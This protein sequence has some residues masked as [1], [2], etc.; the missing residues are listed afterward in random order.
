MEQVGGTTMTVESS[1]T[2]DSRSPAMSTTTVVTTSTSRVRTT[3]SRGTPTTVR[4]STS[5]TR[6]GQSSTTVGFLEPSGEDPLRR[7]DVPPQGVPGQLNF[8]SPTDGGCEERGPVPSVVPVSETREIGDG[9][10]VCISGFEASSPVAVEVSVPGGEIRRRSLSNVP[11]GN[12]WDFKLG[13]TDPVGAYGI[14][15]VQGR[16][17]VTGGFT[18]V[19]PDRPIIEAVPPSSGSP[20]TVF[21]FSIVSPGPTQRVTIDLYR[22]KT[23]ATTLGTIVTDAR[24]RAT[25]ELRT[26]R[27]S[28]AGDYCLVARPF[29]PMRCAS[30]TVR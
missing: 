6:A 19:L 24:S 12:Y 3:T 5:T 27:D 22:A 29:D 4:V 9:V 16:V 15:A 7:R 13:L 26:R 17:R 30:F 28:P 18:A 10:I 1:T 23:F 21:R 14:T 8:L 11:S 20:G 25:Y 2:V